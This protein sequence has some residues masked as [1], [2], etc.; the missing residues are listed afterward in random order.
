MTEGEFAPFVE[1]LV[2]AA[3]LVLKPCPIC[4]GEVRYYEYGRI[5]GFGF[6]VE[7]PHCHLSM[8]DADENRLIARW[9]RMG[10]Q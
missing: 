9:N 3:E 6:E 5:G 4:K 8:T 2:R 1:G 10:E 7:C